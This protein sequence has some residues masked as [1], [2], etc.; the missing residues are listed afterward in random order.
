MPDSYADVEARITEAIDSI[1]TTENANLT[2]VAKD[3]T[4]PYSRLL[5]RFN[6]TPSKLGLASAN[7][8]LSTSEEEALC[9][10]INRLD[11]LGSCVQL[12]ALRN[13]TNLI[14]S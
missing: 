12:A 10:Y 1:S 11:K 5:R 14:L 6:G 3:F 8:K 9:R 7:R 2:Q 4:V 13:A